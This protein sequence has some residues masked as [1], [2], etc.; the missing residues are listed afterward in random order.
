MVFY[1][2][3]RIEMVVLFAVYLWMF[4][5]IM[6]RNKQRIKATFSTK[7]LLALFALLLFVFVGIHL[8]PYDSY[9]P[10]IYD[11]LGNYTIMEKIMHSRHV[12]WWNVLDYYTSRDFGTQLLG[13]DLGSEYLHSGTLDRAHSTYIKGLYAIGYLG[14]IVTSIFVYMIFQKIKICRN[15]NAFFLSGAM[16]ILLLLT[17]LTIESFESTQMS[18]FPFIFAGAVVTM[19]RKTDVQ[20]GK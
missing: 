13:I 11:D 20:Y 8:I 9:T 1:S 19:T 14:C 17:A 3:A 15:R 18:W 16:W 10:R 4:I 2:N 5:Y 7:G 6:N 12:I